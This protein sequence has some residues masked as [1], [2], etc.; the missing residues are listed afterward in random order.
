MKVCTI[1]YRVWLCVLQFVLKLLCL[2]NYIQF[3]YLCSIKFLAMV[4]DCIFKA[5]SDLIYDF[6]NF[7]Y[8]LIYKFI[9]FF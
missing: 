1:S 5:K 8:L 2:K 4:T 3:Q 7:I 6:K 9:I